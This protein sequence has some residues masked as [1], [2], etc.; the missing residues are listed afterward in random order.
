MVISGC[1]GSGK[2][3]LGIAQ[4]LRLAKEGYRV[5][6]T[7]FNTRLRDDLR[8]RYAQEGLE[9]NNVH[10][11]AVGL[12]RRAGLEL[13]EVDWNELGTDFWDGELPEKLV[14]AAAAL[15]VRYDAVM[16][17][18]AQDLGNSW[19]DSLTC[20]LVDPG[21]SPVWLF[22]DDSQNVYGS[23]LEVPAEYR[24]F[25]LSVNC[26]NTRAIHH[27]VMKAYTGSVTPEVRGP[28]GRPPELL[29]AEDQSATVAAVLERLCVEEEVHPHDVVVLSS[30]G[31]K[32]SR[33][34]EEGL[35]GR[36]KLS[37]ARPPGR[38]SVHFSS[39]RGFKG[40]ESS[41]VILCELDGIDSQTI[42]QQLYVGLS[43]AKTHCVIVGPA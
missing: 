7:C 12:I 23:K 39:I 37:A 11:L 33:V 20:L 3:M 10:G 15:G 6:F 16:I 22:K 31:E 25:E 36:L 34:Y 35:P 38:D 1:A 2:T 21:A 5:L 17:D 14:E 27:E 9:I 40:L 41:V 18:E 19:L 42:D 32:R 28:E 8:A 30:H 29:G 13:P 43:R 26:R 4:A 24:P